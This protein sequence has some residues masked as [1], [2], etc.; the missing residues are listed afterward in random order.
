M[1]LSLDISTSVIGFSCFNDKG[2]LIECDYIKFNSK[3]SL[4]EKVSA[5]KEKI[6]HYQ[7]T[8]IT[9]IGIEEPLKRFKGKFSNA[10]TISLLNFFNGMI[11]SYL[12]STFN[13]EPQ[14]FDVKTARKSAFP[15]LIQNTPEI[16]HEVWKRVM[17]I[18]PKINWKYSKITGKLM[19]EN[20]DMSDSVVVGLAYINILLD[21]G[22]EFERF[23]KK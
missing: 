20:Y 6:Q 19:D 23:K 15:S 22:I 18:E 1:L 3:Y 10:N 7:F 8:D 2:M 5:F 17:E 9:H 4:F 14:Y 12:F 16:K 21:R 13:I 11:S